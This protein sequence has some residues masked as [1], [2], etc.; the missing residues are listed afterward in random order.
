MSW[1]KMYQY[2]MSRA[3]IFDLMRGGCGPRVCGAISI[4]ELPKILDLQRRRCLLPPGEGGRRPD[5]G[6]QHIRLKTLTRRC[7]GTLSRRERAD[8]RKGLPSR[9]VVWNALRRIAAR[10]SPYRSNSCAVGN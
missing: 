7:R 2:R 9:K 5:E 3:I 1:Y 10:R 6:L 4:P 8:S